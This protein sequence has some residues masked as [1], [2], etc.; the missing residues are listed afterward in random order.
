MTNPFDLDA[1][2]IKVGTVDNAG[3]AEP[4]TTAPCVTIS[5]LS[6]LCCV[7]TITLLACRGS[8]QVE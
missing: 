8:E 2:D 3:V 4:Q 6:K 5:L 1:L 7:V